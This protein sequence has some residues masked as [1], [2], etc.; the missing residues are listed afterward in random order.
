MADILKDTT[1]PPRVKTIMWEMENM[2]DWISNG[3]I[4]D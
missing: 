2:L 4:P 1:H 3:L